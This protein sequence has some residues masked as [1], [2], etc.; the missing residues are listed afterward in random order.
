MLNIDTRA[1]PDVVYLQLAQ[2]AASDAIEPWMGGS[3]ALQLFSTGTQTRTYDDLI[4]GARKITFGAHEVDLSTQLTRGIRLRTPLVSSP[5]DTVTEAGMAV[6]MAEVGGIGI[7]HY[8]CSV[9]HQVEQVCIA[10]RHVPGQ[11]LIPPT[12]PPTATVKDLLALKASTGT[13]SV[14]ITESGKVGARLLGLVC[15]GDYGL[16]RDL[17]TPLSAIMT[18]DVQTAAEGTL[19]ATKAAEALAA[20]RKGHL[21]IVNAAGELTSLFTRADL[22][23]AAQLPPRGAPSL[24]SDGRL[25][26]GASVGTRDSDKERLRQLVEAGID[27]VVIDSSQGWSLFQLDMLRHIKREHP[28]L[29][30][31]AGNVINAFQ[32]VELIEAGA[33]ALRV[34]MGSGSICTTQEVCAVGRGQAEAVFECARVA[35]KFGVPVLADGGVQNGGHIT[36]ALALGASTVMCGS[37]FAGTEEAPGQYVI[38]DGVRV[39]KYRGMGSLDAMTQGSEQRYL[40]DTQSLKIAQGVS[41]TVRDKGS[42]R[43]NVPF[44]MQAVR[45]G[46]QD[47]GA[48]SVADAHAAL[49]AGELRLRDRTGAA[50]VEGGIH[51]MHSYTKQA[52]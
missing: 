49:A 1:S 20:S 40:S 44:L 43:R 23:R 17:S 33:D 51:D 32:V 5:M 28:G 50:L 9:E 39:K 36:K 35:A 12:L 14:C 26:V 21:P 41:G 18:T 24:S 11:V 47:F 29:Q 34:G 52:W 3:T 30:I 37:L 2:M 19:D 25:L 46:F 6:A 27:V 16:V 22:M 31:I 4:L 38:V 10:K 15:V 48:R 7:I 13:S 45:Q 42:V 8:N